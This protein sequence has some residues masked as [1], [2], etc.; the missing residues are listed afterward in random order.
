M[1]DKKR[2][3]LLSIRHVI[4]KY[5]IIAYYSFY[6]IFGSKKKMDKLNRDTIEN[7]R[8]NKNEITILLHG[9]FLKYYRSMYG[10]AGY[11]RKRGINAV[12]V[13]YDSLQFSNIN[14]AK[15]VKLEIKKIMKQADVK[16]VNIIGLS[17]GGAIA[18]YIVEYLN[19]EKMINKL[20]TFCTM[21]Q[22]KTFLVGMLMSDIDK[23][24]SSNRKFFKK[25]YEK[26]T[27]KNHLAIYGLSDIFMGEHY[28]IKQKIKQIGV[29]GGHF[30]MMYN[31]IALDVAIKY[32][33]NEKITREDNLIITN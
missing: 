3:I 33:K 24:H 25:I 16:K 14:S 12:S 22:D 23:T 4:K 5:L 15:K 29:P 26:Y 2:G 19:K 32:L 6:S 10:T 21:T 11:L 1:K 28:P 31:P 17:L 9:V 30:F 27:F 18:R 8:K 20:I 7:V 13:G